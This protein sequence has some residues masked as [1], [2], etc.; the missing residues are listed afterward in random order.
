MTAC[1]ELTNLAGFTAELCSLFRSAFEN[2][3]LDFIV[4]CPPLDQAVYVD[5]GMWEK[6]VLNLL[7]N[8]FKFT[9]TGKIRWIWFK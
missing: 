2:A 3:G 5:R 6:I 8:T 1:Y 7:S 9:F 4:N